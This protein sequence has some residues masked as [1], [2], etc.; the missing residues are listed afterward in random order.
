MKLIDRYILKEAVPFIL[1]GSFIFT[2]II[3]MNEF[4]R[5]TELVINKGLSVI[6]VF[7]MILLSLPFILS[8]SIPMSLLLGILMGLS[9]LSNDYEIIAMKSSGISIFKMLKPL[10]FL[11]IL[12]FL[13][14]AFLMLDLLPYSNHKFRSLKSQ[15]LLS[16]ATAGLDPKVFNS[17]YENILLYTENIT[18]EGIMEGLFIS[19][20]RETGKTSIILA[21]EG[22]FI[23]KPDQDEIILRLVNGSIHIMESFQ[24]STYDISKFNTQDIRIG[25]ETEAKSD[26]TPKGIKEMTVYELMEQLNSARESILKM[27]EK[28]MG[29][30]VQ[31]LSESQKHELNILENE[32]IYAKKLVNSIRLEYAKK[33]S[34]PFSC[35]IFVLISLPFGTIFSRGGKYSGIAVSLFIIL[36]YYILFILGETLGK[37]GY[38]NPVLSIW[39][40]N[41]ILGAV[42]V[43]LVY[44]SSIE[45]NNRFIQ[46]LLKP[47]EA[48]VTRRKTNTVDRIHKDSFQDSKEIQSARL[49]SRTNL[50]MI[51]D[52]Y[53][54]K[55]FIKNFAGVISI[56]AILFIVIDAFQIIDD[57]LKNQ[58]SLFNLLLYTIYRAPT[59]LSYAIPFSTLL[60]I[61]ITIGLFSKNNEITAFKALG[62]SIYRLF[63]PF[64]VISL[65][66]SFGL[67]WI[68]EYLAPQALRKSRDVKNY[69]IRKKD[70]NHSFMQ[71]QEWFHGLHNSIYNIHIVDPKEIKLY[72]LMIY[73]YS[74][75][76]EMKQ[77][78]HSALA[79]YNRNNSEWIFYNG[80][81]RSFMPDN[82]MKY[83]T[84]EKLEEFDQF[85]E[86]PDYFIREQRNPMEMNYAELGEYVKRLEKGGYKSMEFVVSLYFK[87]AYPFVCLVLAFISF[88]FGLI[89]TRKAAVF[90]G[91]VI[92]ILL[93]I[94]YWIL[95]A[96]FQS[97]GK[98]E[99][100]PP[101][102]AAWA[103][104]IIFLLLGIYLLFS[105]DT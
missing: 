93:G 80:W 11:G 73:S 3:L 13:I 52:R 78:I 36:I 79:E 76:F 60:A 39:M 95:L 4:F 28:K 42:S 58:S 68:N 90:F 77:V 94:V 70:R 69:D 16:K 19:D 27:T 91:V 34:L 8:L 30:A 72:N 41:I 44:R 38:I 14:C 22:Y 54:L 50:L 37:E 64:M 24:K 101:F 55:S 63:I 83:E 61:L 25:F 84:F 51:L 23:S 99:I 2:F 104:N 98:A 1:M 62:I 103:A 75:D 20:E 74:D 56:S 40:P 49:R 6:Y 9:R 10:L 53:L 33:F 92:S 85:N 96:L 59:L 81:I 47:L 17:D 71:N 46:K 82:S 5:F 29:Y 102:L 18:K 21:Q 65:I 97:L 45:A 7:K 48:I 43:F 31:N 66:I 100:L 87:V 88:P 105:S 32:L 15:I 57:V 89:K 86:E 67:F 26:K 12:I 35:I